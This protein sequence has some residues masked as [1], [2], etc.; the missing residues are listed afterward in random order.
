MKS[1]RL[2][3]L[4]SLLVGCGVPQCAFSQEDVSRIAGLSAWYRAD[5]VTQGSNNVLTAL[6]DCSK[7]A[8]HIV[9]GAKPPAVVTQV[10]HGQPARTP[11]N[12]RAIW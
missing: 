10:I 4:L 8:R 11:T 7:N 12:R 6:N 9:V 1:L 2:S 5:H 3:L